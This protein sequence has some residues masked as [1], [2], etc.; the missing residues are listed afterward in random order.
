[1]HYHYRFLRAIADFRNP[2]I[3][4]DHSNRIAHSKVWRD[5]W[6]GSVLDQSIPDSSF[7]ERSIPDRSRPVKRKQRSNN[8]APDR[9]PAA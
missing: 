8:R 5:E 7:R 6:Q 4:K 2:H 1:M 9:S 3:N